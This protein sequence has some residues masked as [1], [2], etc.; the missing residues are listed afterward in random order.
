MST[1]RDPALD[2]AIRSLRDAPPAAD[3]WPEIAPRLAPRRARGTILL[4]W[5][6]AL[7]AGLTIAVVTAGG[8]ALWLRRAPSA[9]PVAAGAG[10]PRL[11][12]A[13]Y[14]A[15]DSTL[16]SA[17]GDLEHQ[18]RATAAQLDAPT[19]DGILRSLSTL[20]QAIADANAR[21]RQAP[22]DPVASRYLTTTLRR[23]LDALR[24]V[25][26]LTAHRS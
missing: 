19:R 26:E 18:V 22:N 15:A 7:A 4:R 2:A 11:S 23:K 9:V 1:D 13:H 5:P 12:E 3:L 8:T 16:A 14:S 10:G 21:L 17:I 6:T 25:S 20:D 24:T